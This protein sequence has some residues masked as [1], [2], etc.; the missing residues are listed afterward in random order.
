MSQVR[1]FLLQ[2]RGE[3]MLQEQ[4]ARELTILSSATKQWD[5]NSYDQ[6]LEAIDAAVACG[7]IERQNG[8]VRVVYEPKKKETVKQRSLFE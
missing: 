2:E 8:M 6:W 1:E 7:E 5:Q 4:A 3:W